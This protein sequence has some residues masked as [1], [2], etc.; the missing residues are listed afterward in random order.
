MKTAHAYTIQEALRL[1]EDHNYDL[2]HEELQVILTETNEDKM[3]D[4]LRKLDLLILL[5][6]FNG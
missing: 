5:E 3:K 6:S 1:V 2:D 4:L